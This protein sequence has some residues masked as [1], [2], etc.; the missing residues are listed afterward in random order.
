M[1]SDLAESYFWI[2]CLVINTVK[3]RKKIRG[4]NL[5]FVLSQEGPLFGY[6]REKLSEYSTLCIASDH[7][8]VLI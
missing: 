7:S 3:N 1:S 8:G 4:E 2:S 5:V 6:E